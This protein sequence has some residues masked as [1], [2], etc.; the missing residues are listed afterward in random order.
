M[1][2]VM[3]WPSVT[4]CR[5][6]EEL[7]AGLVDVAKGKVDWA[8]VAETALLAQRVARCDGNA[9]HRIIEAIEAVARR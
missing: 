4:L 8:A 2:E 5:S 3:S 9:R 7:R 6:W 1:R